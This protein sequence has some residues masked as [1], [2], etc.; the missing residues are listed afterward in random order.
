MRRSVFVIVCML[1]LGATASQRGICDAADF[2]VA[3][4]AG[5]HWWTQSGQTFR[6]S[7][8]DD[9]EWNG[10]AGQVEGTCWWGWLGVYA[11]L[12]MDADVDEEMFPGKVYEAEIWYTGL[13]L[14]ARA[15]LAENLKGYVGY[16]INFTEL[17]NTY[18]GR[19]IETWDWYEEPGHDFLLGLNYYLSDHWFMATHARYTLN[20]KWSDV[21]HRTSF[22]PDGLRGWV[23]LGYKF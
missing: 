4:H 18:C 12:G 10:W 14:K 19:H 20:K 5:Y 1:V 6:Y 23:G 3:A 13:G 15:D 21:W 16:G 17:K 8:K 2:E 9:K 22:N 11:F 7:D